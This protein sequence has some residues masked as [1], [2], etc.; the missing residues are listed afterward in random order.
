MV[1]RRNILE[2]L[3]R[4]TLLALAR[5]FEISGLSGKNK[6]DIVAALVRKLLNDEIAER[7]RSNIV[8]GRSFADM[9]QKAIVRYQNRAIEP[10]QVIEEL[11]DWRRK[12][13][14]RPPAAKSWG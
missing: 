1:K 3:T 4:T 9:L 2:C 12:C 14:R 7:S 11:I 10:A 5:S 8:L 6:A 13:A